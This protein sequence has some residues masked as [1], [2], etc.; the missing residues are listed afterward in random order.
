MEVFLVFIAYSVFIFAGCIMVQL[1]LLRKKRVDAD[2]TREALE[3]MLVRDCDNAI[4]KYRMQFF[5]VPRKDVGYLTQVTLTHEANMPEF[6]IAFAD[7]CE[8]ILG[9]GR[10]LKQE[11]QG[12]KLKY[13][14]SGIVSADVQPAPYPVL[15][16]NNE[17]FTLNEA[18]K[19]NDVIDSRMDKLVQIRTAM[20][21]A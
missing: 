16:L 7:S 17:L 5:R 3:R 14:L 15:S 19:A 12:H 1:Y 2:R 18:L 4:S 13:V 8:R 6:Y 20:V 21:N 9:Y 11:M 10:F